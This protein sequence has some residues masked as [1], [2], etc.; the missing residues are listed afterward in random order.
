VRDF[1]E[2][3]A[4]AHSWYKHLRVL[5]A[6]A[7]LQFFLD[8]AAGMQLTQAADGRV[9]AA[10][11]EKRGL[12]YSWLPTSE[13]RRRFG[14]LAFSKSS[15]TSVSELRAD[16][17]RH[18]AADNAPRIHDP[19]AQA[20]Y[21]L[22]AEALTAGRAFISGIVHRSASSKYIWKDVI[23]RAERFDD[24]LDPI[25]GL[26]IGKRILDR[27]STLKEDPSR[28][29]PQPP[30]Q[31][32]VVNEYSLAAFDFPLH[33]LVEAERRRQIEGMVAAAT[34]LIRLVGSRA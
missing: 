5:P 13:Y 22:P 7:P 1:A 11:R 3:V 30:Q 27:C 24:V 23:E 17:S 20:S 34:R 25:D 12:H 33:Q 16:G 4:G 9:T 18:I 32:R 2:Y 6:S 8:P 19:A 15:G 21:A 31:D 28:A 10:P 26:E 29:E 14:Y